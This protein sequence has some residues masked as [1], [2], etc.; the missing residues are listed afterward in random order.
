MSERYAVMVQFEN[1]DWLYVTTSGEN[2]LEDL[3]V[4]TWDDSLAAED[5]ADTIRLDGREA[6]VKV[7]TYNGE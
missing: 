7:V 1:D 4:K 2:G 3:K 5:F 6:N